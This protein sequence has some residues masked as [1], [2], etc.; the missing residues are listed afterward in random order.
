MHDPK[1]GHRD[2]HERERKP[3]H[4]CSHILLLLLKVME[5]QIILA[6]EGIS[7]DIISIILTQ[8]SY[9]LIIFPNY[10]RKRFVLKC[11]SEEEIKKKFF[12]RL[13]KHEYFNF[14]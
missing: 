1:N 8:K 7:F 6:P 14:S 10:K 5:N 9:L 13:K 12:R 11:F 3:R 2:K 4:F